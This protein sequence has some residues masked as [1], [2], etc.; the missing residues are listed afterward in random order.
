VDFKLSCFPEVGIIIEQVANTHKSFILGNGLR[1]MF[2]DNS[3]RI[4]GKEAC[5]ARTHSQRLQNLIA[6]ENIDGII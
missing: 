1:L 3:V 5:W 2:F 6:T 4:R